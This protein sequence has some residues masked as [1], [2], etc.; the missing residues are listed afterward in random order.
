MRVDKVEYKNYQEWH[1]GRTSSAPLRAFDYKYKSGRILINP[2]PGKRA[3]DVSIRYNGICYCKTFDVP[4]DIIWHR[5]EKGSWLNRTVTWEQEFRW[6]DVE[7]MKLAEEFAKSILD[8]IDLLSVKES[9]VVITPT[10]I[11]VVE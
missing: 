10:I 4:C 6:R 7:T 5:V 2:N 11:P 9:S 1:K 3:I 8:A